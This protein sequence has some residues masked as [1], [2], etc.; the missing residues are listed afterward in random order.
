MKTLPI[1]GTMK[2]VSFEDDD[3]IDLVRQLVA[4]EMNSHPDRMFLEVKGKFPKDYYSSNP[5]NWSDLFFRLSFDGKTIPL[6]SM[7]TYTTQTRPGLAVAP[8]AV[9]REQ[10]EDHDEFLKPI[11]DPEDD[12][13]EWRILGAE[14]SIVLPIP[15]RDV[16]VMPANIPIPRT[17]SLVDTLHPYEITEIRATILPEDASELVKRNYYPRLRSDT[18]PNIETLRS[19]ITASQEQF[20]KLLKLDAPAAEKVSIVRAK[21]YI[22]WISTRFATPRARFE[23]IFYGMTLSDDT[24]Y[25]GYFTAK[26]ET[27][28]HKFYVKNP[29]DKKIPEDFKGWWKGWLASTLPQRRTPTLLLYR[30]TSRVSFDRIAITSKDVTVD[31]HREKT[32]TQSLDELK[33]EVLK[34]LM[35]FDALVPFVVSSDMDVKRWELGDL[36]MV[37][38]YAKEVQEFDM[39]RFPCLQTMFSFQRD[40]FR[41]LRAE[42]ASN[43]ISPR[44]LQAYQILTQDDAEQT[45]EYLAREMDITPA[46]AAELFTTLQNRAED[47]DIEKS[48]KSYPVIKFSN[49]DVIVRFITNPE[50]TLRYADILRFVLTS[51]SESV[52]EVCPRRMEVVGPKVAV[53][54]QE[55]TEDDV[56]APVDLDFGF[57]DEEEEEAPAGEQPAAKPKK[58]RVGERKGTYNYFNNRLQKFDP[59]TFDKSIYPGK[60]DKPKQV[61]ALKE[62]DKDRI[63]DEYNYRNAPEEEVLELKDPDATVLCPPYWCMRDEIPLREEQL[64]LGEDGELHCPVCT[65]KVRPNDSADTIEFTVIKRDVSAKYPDYLRQASTINGRKIPCCYQQPRSNVEVLATKEEVMYVRDASNVQLPMFRLGYLSEQLVQQLKI[66]PNYAESVKKGR[67]ITGE[68]G[69]FRVGMGRPSKSLPT[70]L[71]DK[72]PV[73]RPRDAKETLLQCSFVRTWSTTHEGDTTIDRIVSSIDNEYQQGTLPFLD[74]LEYVTA[75]LKSKVILINS[76]D[77]QV[78]CGFWTSWL[79]RTIAVIDN[80]ILA[81][82]SRRKGQKAGAKLEYV[83][84]LTKEPFAAETYPL[85]ENMHMRACAT[86]MPTLKDAIDELKGKESDYSVILDPYER[87]QAVFVPKK[88]V[89]PVIPFVGKPE[90]GVGVRNGYVNIDKDELP[91]A[92]DLRAFLQQTIHPKFKIVR[93][94]ANAGGEISEFLLASGLRAPVK[95]ESEKHT[96]PEEVLQTIRLKDEA[97]LVTGTPVTKDVEKV[98]YSEEIFQFLMYSLAKDVQE[99]D[100]GDLREAIEKKSDNLYK[101]LKTWMD[102]NTYSDATKS[103]I[104]F[105]NKVRTPCGQFTPKEGKMTKEQK[106]ACNNSSLCG[107]VGNTCKIRVKPIVDKA[108][109]LRRLV[110]VLR[111]N[112]KQRALVLDNRISPFFSTILYLEMPNELITTSV[113]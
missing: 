106:D 59:K 89:L 69:V 43:D 62:E 6:E 51:E 70:L 108:A 41:L 47:F 92:E 8:Q 23:Q 26:T 14:R 61:I 32:S 30:G 64:K 105:I 66:K 27:I 53:P 44:E 109:V 12:F 81:K 83:V 50:R 42:H 38:S 76:V 101:D 18:P 68:Y 39:L 71:G 93:E 54:Q 96:P 5:K 46:E 36:S 100:N 11:F 1:S 86:D 65:G 97:T 67:L 88:I 80:N 55:I 49:K 34:W 48:L 7:K 75:F 3:T 94:L 31:V 63:G 2:S 78:V 72:T 82:V 35:T 9:T 110:K 22:P 33:D 13:E 52:N 87:I 113:S 85:L 112:D 29:K 40:A 111:E 73:P 21:W 17:Q 10:W 19:S 57:E 37:G 25:I 56:F 99:D 77:G 104:E 4:L 74:E 103:P 91:K 16:P 60:C 28:R 45:P 58:M 98:T 95:P 90:S 24:P 102:S 15:P 79:Q 107:V 84:D 20:R